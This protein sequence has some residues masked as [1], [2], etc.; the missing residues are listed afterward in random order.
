MAR[1]SSSGVHTRAGRQ[2]G[3]PLGTGL[4][5]GM[6]G[7]APAGRRSCAW[8]GGAWLIW[9]DASDVPSPRIEEGT[10]KAATQKRGQGQC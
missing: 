10:R 3:H 8:K 5:G 6:R 9:M 1:R 2:R 4:A 7:A